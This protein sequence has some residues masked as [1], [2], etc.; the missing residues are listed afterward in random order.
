MPRY[1]VSVGTL[2][3]GL[4]LDADLGNL[5]GFPTTA[6]SMTFT[7]Q[8]RSGDGPTASR[9]FTLVVNP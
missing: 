6:G 7:V 2:P 1:S 3:D 8:V 9:E 4:S 5:S